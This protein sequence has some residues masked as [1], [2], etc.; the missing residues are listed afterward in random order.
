MKL[1]GIQFPFGG[2][3]WEID[4]NEKVLATNLIDYLEGKRV[5]Y[6]ECKRGCRNCKVRSTKSVLE[7]KK[8]TTNM[9]CDLH[10]ETDFKRAV[11]CIRQESNIF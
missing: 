9:L 7:I 3:S 2:I 5:L 8:F 10:K 11:R 1:T 4:E 6:N